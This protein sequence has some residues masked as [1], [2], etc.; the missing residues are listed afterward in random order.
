L[1]F[2]ILGPEDGTGERQMLRAG[3]I[4]MT[5]GP[6]KAEN[7]RKAQKMVDEAVKGGAELIL[8]PELFSFLPPK[9]DPEAYRGNSEP[10]NGPTLNW[11]RGVSRESGAA[12]VGGSIIEARGRKLYNTSCLILPSGGVYAYSKVHLFKYGE[13]NETLVFTAGEGGKVFGWDK[14][15]LGLTIC[16]DLRFPELYVA[17]ALMGANVFCN[18]A[19][20]LE[21]TGRAHWFS[22]LRARAIENQVFVLAVNQ[23]G[24][25]EAGPRYY[26]NSCIVDPWGKV[27]AK[28]GRG[29]EVLFGDINL[30]KVEEIRERLPSLR[31]RRPEAYGP[32][33]K[34][35]VK[36]EV[37]L[38]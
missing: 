21:S 26:G 2:Y 19:A 28:A 14:L 37:L 38:T 34:K 10:L 16:Y 6:I 7:I 12:I 33:I 32:G 3:I 18:V 35:K 1:G 9:I 30:A 27:V 11:L 36:D 15:R 23:A 5:S 29:E 24:S 4:Q 17:E 22:L 20:F 31:A 13:I 8:F 25:S